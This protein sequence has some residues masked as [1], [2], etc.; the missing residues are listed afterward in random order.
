MTMDVTRQLPPV[1]RL[2]FLHPKD[3]QCV[4]LHGRSDWQGA[5]SA[6]PPETETHR[7]RRS[8]PLHG[9]HAA[10]RFV[11]GNTKKSR[12][13]IRPPGRFLDVALGEPEALT[14]QPVAGYGIQDSTTTFG[15][16]VKQHAGV[17]CEA[18]R[19]VQRTGRYE[20]LLS[21]QA[22]ILNDDTIHVPVALHHRNLLAV[23]A[24]RGLGVV[25]PLEGDPLGCA[26][27]HRN[28]VDLRPAGSIRG[29]VDALPV[30]R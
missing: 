11:H 9:H 20:A 25:L 24:H 3:R 5:A 14:D 4:M 17:G 2:L 29:E 6:S 8:G 15:G 13:P 10:T 1:N 23:V 30:G 12:F 26:A 18:D 22:L 28:L 27:G 7:W 21:A 19:V 16:R